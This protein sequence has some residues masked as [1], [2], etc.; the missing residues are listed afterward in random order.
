[1]K[2]AK[3]LGFRPMESGMRSDYLRC[4][5]LL[6]T[7]TEDVPWYAEAFQTRLFCDEGYYEIGD[8]GRLYKLYRQAITDVT[9]RGAGAKVVREDLYYNG[10]VAFW[11]QGNTVDG[12]L[13]HDTYYAQFLRGQLVAIWQPGAFGD[14]VTTQEEWD[15]WERWRNLKKARD[16]K[17]ATLTGDERQA[18][19]DA[20]AAERKRAAEGLGSAMADSIRETSNRPGFMRRFLNT[21]GG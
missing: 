4:N 3:E 9:E 2:T 17:L 19:L 16:A 5:R 14:I 13:K 21:Q 11:G 1:M 6:H 20:E 18:F 8:D 7:I 12:Y 10:I 15:A